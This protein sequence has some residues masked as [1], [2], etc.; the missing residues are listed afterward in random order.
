MFSEILTFLSHHWILATGFVATLI[1]FLWHEVLYQN[2]QANHALSTAHLVQKMNHESVVIVDIRSP[3]LYHKGS[4]LNAI[5]M[6]ESDL[7]KKSNPLNKYKGKTLVFVCEQGHT[8][9]KAADKAR[10]SGAQALYLIG[11]IQA[12]RDAQLPIVKP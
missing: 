8:A 4:I 12:W 10:K 5:H 6:P 1:L 11:G 7:D 3:T 9:A 2:Q